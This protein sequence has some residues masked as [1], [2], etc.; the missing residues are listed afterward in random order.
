VFWH[1]DCHANILPVEAKPITCFDHPDSFDLLAIPYPVTVLR[2]PD[3]E[4]VLIG[5][6]ASAL[7]LDVLSGSL[8][9]G[10]VHLEYCLSGFA[11]LDPKI[12]TLRK[13]LAL[14][15]LGRLP[16]TL[17]PPSR[18]ADRWRMTLQAHDGM[19]A[20]ASQREIAIALFGEQRV[21]AD[22]EAGYLRTRIQRLIRTAEKMIR[23]GGYRLLL[24]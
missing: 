2:S 20:G 3:G 22:W 13:L 21:N 11:G 17:C 14:E 16:A 19:R 12:M 4:H 6:G 8:L 10:P 24:R 15:R 7:R 1:G 18:K 23:G 9:A 5:S